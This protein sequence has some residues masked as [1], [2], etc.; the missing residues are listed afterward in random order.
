MADAS[1]DATVYVAIG[2]NVSPHTHVPAAVEQLARH[3]RLT[4]LSRFYQTP[5]IGRS[6]QDDFINGVARLET[7]FP[8]AA[9][10]YDVLRVIERD[11]GRTRDEDLYAPRTMDLDILLYGDLVC[12]E[13]GLEI[14]DPD[15]LERAFLIEGL[16]DLEPGLRLPGDTLPLVEH[17]LK[18][19]A[20]ITLPDFTTELRQRWLVG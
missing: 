13:P 12:D 3:A 9:F 10:K 18:E 1:K 17:R 20:L 7:S 2:S 5:A 4:G 8:P 14:P 11:L 6:D 15:I 19:V 16:L